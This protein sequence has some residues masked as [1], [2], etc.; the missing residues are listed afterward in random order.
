M[1]NTP[2]VSVAA[3]VVAAGRGTRA[4]GHQAKQWRIIA[5]QRVFDHTIQAFRSHPR[6]DHIVIALRDEDMDQCPDDCLPVQGGTDRAGSVLSGLQALAPHQP[7][8]VLIHDVARPCVDHALI[9]RVLD[10]LQTCNGA[11]PALAVTDALWTGTDGIVSGTRDRTG[12]FRAQTPQGFRFAEIFAAHQSH[13]GGAADDVEVAR[14]AG[15]DVA[16][17]KGDEDNLKITHPQDFDRAA[18][19]LE[20]RNGYQ[21][22]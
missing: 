3:V 4:G 14:A 7:A 22:G 10:G 8:F 20:T 18:R 16:I 19:I 9:E 2:S 5:G 11:A 17:V 1:T 21:T 15:L 13:P 6:V 12:L